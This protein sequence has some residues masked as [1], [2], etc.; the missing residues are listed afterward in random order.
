MFVGCR[1]WPELAL[2]SQRSQEQSSEPSTSTATPPAPAPASP[3][4]LRASKKVVDRMLAAHHA[5]VDA[6]KALGVDPC[7]EYKKKQAPEILARVKSGH[8][9]CTV[10]GKIVPTLKSLKLILGANMLKIPNINVESVV[11]SV[12][13]PGH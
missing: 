6:L 13:M 5:Q 4:Q 1:E 8:T 2:P 11:R 3:E 12:G 7:L 10:C 9:I